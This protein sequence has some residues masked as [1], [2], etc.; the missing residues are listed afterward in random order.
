MRVRRQSLCRLARSTR[1]YYRWPARRF[2][3][4]RHERKRCPQHQGG[5]HPGA[6][7]SAPHTI[8]CS[9]AGETT[10]FGAFTLSRLSNRRT[11]EICGTLPPTAI[12]RPIPL[13]RESDSPGARRTLVLPSSAFQVTDEGCTESCAQLSFQVTRRGLRRVLKRFDPQTKN[14]PSRWVF[15]CRLLVE[16]FPKPNNQDR[17]GTF[18]LKA[19]SMIPA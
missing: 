5:Q 18:R 10:H 15:C 13:S 17:F 8:N 6:C 4:S 2:L 14:P 9:F 1:L 3:R 19:S 11:G 7:P 12:L 16:N